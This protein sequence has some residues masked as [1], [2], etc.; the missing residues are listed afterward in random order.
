MYPLGMR[1]K[2]A[3]VSATGGALAYRRHVCSSTL[4]MRVI[5]AYVYTMGLLARLTRKRP[6]H[7]NRCTNVMLR[8]RDSKNFKVAIAATFLAYHNNLCLVLLHGISDHMRVRYESLRH[9][10]Q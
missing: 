1:R 5:S 4:L 2:P 6:I 3:A 10:S 8:G 7:D 9:F